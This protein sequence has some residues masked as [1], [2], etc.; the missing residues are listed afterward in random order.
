LGD[1]I[2]NYIP[3]SPWA[4]LGQI[5]QGVGNSIASMLFQVPQVRAQQKWR[6]QQ[7][8]HDAQQLALRAQEVG[9]LNRARDASAEYDERRT[10]GLKNE[11]ESMLNLQNVIKSVVPAEWQDT[12][13][14]G[15]GTNPNNLK[16]VVEGLGYLYSLM[17]ANIAGQPNRAMGAMTGR[18]M[19]DVEANIPQGAVRKPFTGESQM[20]AIELSPGA[21]W[22]PPGQQQQFTAPGTPSKAQPP[23]MVGQ[24]PVSTANTIIDA[25]IKAAGLDATPEQIASRV[26]D[27]WRQITGTNM[28]GFNP[29]PIAQPPFPGAVRFRDKR[30]GRVGWADLESIQKNSNLMLIEE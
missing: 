4:E 3:S 21:T 8:Q 2:M 22:L 18:G 1:K 13:S 20:G 15:V 19:Q 17:Q 7:L 29:A 12:F 16:N 14:S 30:N 26:N 9:S 5:G 27:A 25:N 11:Q 6:Q 28:S 23:Q 24:M 10:L